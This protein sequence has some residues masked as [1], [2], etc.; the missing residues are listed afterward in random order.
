MR[1]L[2]RTALVTAMAASMAGAYL[3]AQ[4]APEKF[5][6]SFKVRVG[7]TDPGTLQKDMHA[8]GLLGLGAGVTFALTDHSSVLVELTYT[9]FNSS[10]FANPILPPAIPASSGDLRKNKLQGF[11]VRAGYRSAIGDTKFNW[12]A[13]LILD[14]LKSRQE[15]SGQLT[16]GVDVES[17]AVSVESTKIRPGIF[18][19]IHRDLTSE[20]AFECNLFTVGY[21]RVDWMPHAYSGSPAAPVTTN[22]TGLGLEVSLSLRL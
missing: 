10:P 12:Q 6:S 8:A 22:R 20:M 15:A 3:K 19:G 17:I 4:T 21:S 9:Q 14:R 13:G 1:L 2:L 16:V 7:Y 5:T 18:G 11:S